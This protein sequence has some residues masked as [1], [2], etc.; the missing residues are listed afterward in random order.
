MPTYTANYHSTLAGAMENT[1]LYDHIQLNVDCYLSRHPDA[2]LMVT[3]D[4]IPLVLVST[5]NV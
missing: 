4:L 5:K 3:G 1:E 2:L